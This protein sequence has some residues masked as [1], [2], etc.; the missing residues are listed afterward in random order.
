M[1]VERDSLGEVQVPENALWGPQTERSRHFF[2]TGPLMPLSI[3][4]ALIEIKRA[5]ALANRS[6]GLLSKDQA[7]AIEAACVNL[8]KNPSHEHFPLKVFQTGSGTQSN[9]N[10]NEV[11]AHL[12]RPS[13]IHPHDHVNLSQSSNDVFPT[14]IHIAV[15]VETRTKLLQSLKLLIQHLLEKE[16]AWEGIV[17]LGRTHLMDAVPLYAGQEISA[18][19]SQIE[20][21]SASLERGLLLLMPL[22]I[23]GTAV[24]TGLNCPKGFPE[25]VIQSLSERYSLPFQR[26]KNP[27][28]ALACHDPL[29]DFA[30]SLNRLATA[31]FKIANDIR[32]LASG[33][34]AGFAELKLPENE[35]GSS[36]M[37]GKVNP[38]QCEMMTQVAL[39]CLGL[40]STIT[41]ANTQG[42]LQLNVYKPLI[43]YNTLEIIH[44]LSGA[45]EGFCAFCL[46]DMQLDEKRVD[47]LLQSSLLLATNLV[48]K[49]GYDQVADLVRKA[50]E[51]GLT[52][53]EALQQVDSTAKQGIDKPLLSQAELDELLDPSNMIP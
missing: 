29:V 28:A 33:P 46:K 24:G 26:S 9:M 42:H 47:T 19:R 36:I 17:K 34:R 41:Y 30:G 32:L 31:L 44:L 27:F 23:G 1:R 7:S 4:T 16:R 45:I 38:T 52:L 48:P 51:Q 43:G 11:I 21:C 40:S 53:K 5:A 22:A 8:L 37:P 6:L 15:I 14:A 12:A 49:L 3:L 25:L 35:P 39:Y 10:V 50:H 18:Y 2:P 20:E 13:R